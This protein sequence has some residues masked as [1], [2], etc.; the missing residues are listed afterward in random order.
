MVKITDRDTMAEA[1]SAMT[2]QAKA[3]FDW[4][5]RTLDFRLAAYEPQDKGKSVWHFHAPGNGSELD[6][7]A[8]KEADL[9]WRAQ[10]PLAVQYDFELGEQ[11][12]DIYRTYVQ[13]HGGS[14]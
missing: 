13:T 5:L 2:P 12:R 8:I 3:V 11:V 4:L 9:R 6:A 1:Y 14:I 10:L 7:V